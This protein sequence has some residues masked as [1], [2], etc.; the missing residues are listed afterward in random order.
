[1]NSDNGDKCCGVVVAY[2]ACAEEAERRVAFLMGKGMVPG[3][4][5]ILDAANFGHVRVLQQILDAGYGDVL[6]ESRATLVSRAAYRGHVPVLRWAVEKLGATPADFG[7]SMHRKV[8]EWAREEYTE[9]LDARPDDVALCAI[10]WDDFLTLQRVFAHGD[11]HTLIGGKLFE[12]A[13]Y[14]GRLHIAKW[15][16]ERGARWP[17]EA[18]ALAAYSGMQAALRW[19]AE[20]QNG[21]RR[22]RVRSIL[23]HEPH[24]L[25]SNGGGMSHN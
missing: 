8:L 23:R 11:G 3:R 19:M 21:R 13:L 6:M 16:R 10:V 14:R 17:S 4:Y 22:P 15:L 1:M 12:E 9:L 2:I 25:F 7:P 18:W 5:T 24:K 20:Q